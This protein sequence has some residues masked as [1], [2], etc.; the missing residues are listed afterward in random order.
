MKCHSCI[1][2]QR[3][4]LDDDATESEAEGAVNDP[5]GTEVCAQDGDPAG[6]ENEGNHRGVK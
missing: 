4:V 5:T 6:T 1:L 2:A 3:S